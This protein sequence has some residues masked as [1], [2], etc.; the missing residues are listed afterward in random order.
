MVLTTLLIC[1]LLNVPCSSQEATTRK[2]FELEN[3]L[4]VF[5]YERHNLPLVNV[6]VAVNFGSKDETEETNG[7]AHLLEHY[8][9][10]RGTE[11]RSGPEISKDIRRHGAYF[12]AHTGEDISLFEI[13]I[14]SEYIDFALTNQKEILFNLKLTQEDL[15]EE[16]EVILE[17]LSQV[18][19]DPI[20]YAT[21]LV[22][23]NIFKNHTYCKPIYGKR[24]TIEAITVDQMKEFY[25]KYFVASNCSMAIVGDSALGDMEKKVKAIFGDLK[26]E[27]FAAPQF[28]K[29]S[30]LEKNVE[31]EQEMDVSQAYLVIGMTGPDY[32]HPDQFAIDVL[33]E[34]LGQGVN[35]LLNSVLRGRRDLVQTISM[36]YNSLK[37]GGIILLI[38]TLDPKNLSFAKSAAVDFLRKT[39]NENYSKEDFFGENQIYA[40]D[41][42]GSAKNQIKFDL[43]LSQEISLSVAVSL[44]RYMLLDKNIIKGSY[45]ENIEK[46]SS[47]DLR[48]AAGQYFSRGKY[49]IVSIIPK[50]KK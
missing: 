31:L 17:E 16:K 19:D 6:V 47:S 7:L 38:F 20:K 21:S 14:P 23:Q 34:I 18:H 13:S 42:L 37:Y 43:Q 49:V 15:N 50:K 33:T 40:F 27:V 30:F 25:K 48:K 5:L 11:L 10:F 1:L 41:Y 29:A 32:N 22:Y 36:N 35:P 4:K 24:E 3:G 28:E 45:L 26:K 46:L 44:A 8:I 9:L 39:R 2:Y 12:N